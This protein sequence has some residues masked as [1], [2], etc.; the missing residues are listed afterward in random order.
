MKK[1]LFT[2]VVMFGATSFTAAT[3]GSD[4]HGCNEMYEPVSKPVDCTI[5]SETGDC[6]TTSA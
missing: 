5:D 1:L 2:A 3:A 4:G 6:K